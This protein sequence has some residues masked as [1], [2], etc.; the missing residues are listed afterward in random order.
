MSS[1]EESLIGPKLPLSTTLATCYAPDHPFQSNITKLNKIYTSIRRIRGDGSCF[2]R[3]FLFRLLEVLLDDVEVYDNNYDRI[4]IFLSSSLQNLGEMGYDVMALE[5]FH[6][7]LIDLYDSFYTLCK[8]TYKDKQPDP[9][10]FAMTE[11]E[12]GEAACNYSTWYLRMIVSSHLKSHA[13]RFVNFLPSS[14][15]EGNDL[16][17]DGA[18]L[19]LISIFC[20]TE[21]EPSRVECDMIQVI[22]LAEACGVV[23]NVVYLDGNDSSLGGGGEGVTT[24]NFGEVD[25]GGGGGKKVEIDLIYTPG[26]YDILYR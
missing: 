18:E 21:V 4:Q 20:K 19:S 26:H 1:E 22:A 23:V 5:S 6:E 2:Y 13:K 15:I 17:V 11:G 12:D 25:S 9:L 7:V 8:T 3:G 10:V 14:K 24:H 16:S